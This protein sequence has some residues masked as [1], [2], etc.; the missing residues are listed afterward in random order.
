MIKYSSELAEFVGLVFGDGSVTFR[1]GTNKI[2]FQLR[3]DAKGDRDHYLQFVIPLCNKFF[4]PILGKKVSSVED[5]KKNSFGIAIESPKTKTFF[6]EIGINIGIK[7]ELFIPNWIK[8]NENYSKAFVRGLFDTDGSISY[9]KNNTA[10]NNFHIVGTIGICS[11]SKNLIEET[12]Q[13]LKKVNIKHYLKNFKSQT[14]KKRAYKVTISRPHVRE[15]ITIINSHNPKHLTKY[16]IANKFG[17]CPPYT[18][19]EQRKQILKGFVDPLS[20]YSQ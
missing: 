12:S 5:R 3:G 10:K 14:N 2:R 8:E 6:E 19:F 15:F 11:T 20:L 7:E 1:K 16:K 18:T 13:I 4:E 9:G 17:F